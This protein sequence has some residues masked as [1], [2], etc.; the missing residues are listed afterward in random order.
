MLQQEIAEL[1]EKDQLIDRMN[2]EIREKDRLITDY[3][4]HIKESQKQL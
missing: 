3:E 2:E 4:I 1:R